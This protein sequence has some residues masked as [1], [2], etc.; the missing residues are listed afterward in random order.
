V[1]A[2][3]DAGLTEAVDDS[4]GEGR[5]ASW[6][7]TSKERL[8]PLIRAHGRVPGETRLVLWWSSGRAELSQDGRGPASNL[9]R[10]TVLR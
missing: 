2:V 7:E 5:S 1:G 8:M 4:E 9:P 10:T 6:D 3:G